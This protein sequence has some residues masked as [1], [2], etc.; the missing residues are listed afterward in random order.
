MQAK[1][2]GK[3]WSFQDF[4]PKPN[5]IQCFLYIHPYS[6]APILRPLPSSLWWGASAGA[7]PPLP[8]TVVLCTGHDAWTREAAN[9]ADTEKDEPKPSLE[10]S[11]TCP[12]DLVPPL[13][14]S[15]LTSMITPTWPKWCLRASLVLPEAQPNLKTTMLSHDN[16][17]LENTEF[18]SESPSLVTYLCTAESPLLEWTWVSPK[19][20]DPKE[21]PPAVSKGSE[22]TMGEAHTQ[23]AGV[24]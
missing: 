22:Q 6:M 17:I 15:D 4:H 2:R 1:L 12:R 7:R 24:A 9:G 16:G 8:Q 21:P 5:L 13:S 20:R 10:R 18:S 3:K 19:L 23:A 14:T 11:K